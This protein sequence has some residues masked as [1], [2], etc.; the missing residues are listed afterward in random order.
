MMDDDTGHDPKA[1]ATTAH[2][3]AVWDRMARDGAALA[4]PASDADFANP[5]RTVDPLG[6]LGESIAGW[7]VLCLAAGGGRQSALYAAAGA[8]V[9]VVDISREMLALDNQ[10]AAERGLAV[11]TVQADMNDLGCLSAGQFDL[12]IQ[13]V[14]TCYVP[15]VHRV[16]RQVAR[17]TRPGG[18]YVSQHK[19]PVSLQASLQPREATYTIDEAYYRA[20]PIPKV[21]QPS[22]LRETGAREYLH[23]WEQLIGGL[24]R[25][26][27]AVLDLVEPMHADPKA[28][29]GSFGHRGQ[30][31]APYVRI[32]ARRNEDSS[33]T[34]G[35]LWTPSAGKD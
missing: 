1:D 24:C 10:V 13:P 23:R 18:L 8:Q 30:F 26:G 35:K 31:I 34:A 9:T 2:N 3:A 6:W 17:V 14:S 15:D 25:T 28:D 12:V 19:S 21:D 4:T 5:L 32:K 7:R 22:R 29:V 33:G 27:F 20:G 16:Y 11:K